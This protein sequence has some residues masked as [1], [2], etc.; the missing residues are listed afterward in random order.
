MLPKFDEVAMST[1]FIVLA[2]IRRP[3]IT[4]SARTPRSLSSRTT[5]AA[6]L[7]TSEPE[8]TEIPTSAWCRATASL[9]PSPMNATSRPVLRATLMMR[10]FCSGPIR[11]NTVVVAIAA[12]SPS[13]SRVSTSPPDRV[14]VQ[15]S[16]MSAH[17]LAA[18]RPLS[19]VMI[20][21]SIPRARSFSSELPASAFGRS[22]K[23]RNPSSTRPCSSVVVTV[24]AP[25][26]DRLA[27]ATTRAPWANSPSRTA[28]APAGTDTHRPSTT[29]GA[30]LVTS[31][32]VPSG[33]A[34]ST[35]TS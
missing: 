27:T 5:S 20:L 9:T 13:S 7:A 19:P 4:P 29:S 6:S 1:Y 24:S 32:E 10:D 2:K 8:S 16:P 23:V 26:A 28:R 14:P 21:T 33:A 12:S 3:S 18:T 25:G 15:S 34:T 17:T 31:R 22:A 30:P 11:A 35:D